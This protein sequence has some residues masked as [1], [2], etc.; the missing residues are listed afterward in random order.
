MFWHGWAGS[1]EV[2]PRPHRKPIHA[3]SI[4]M[5]SIPQHTTRCLSRCVVAEYEP[6]AWLETSRVP[7]QTVTCLRMS[8]TYAPCK[9]RMS[10][11]SVAAKLRRTGRNIHGHHLRLVAMRLRFPLRSTPAFRLLL[12]VRRLSVIG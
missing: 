3:R 1:T 2:I 12:L 6:L 8:R 4:F 5:S 7:R 9:Q 10:A 11:D